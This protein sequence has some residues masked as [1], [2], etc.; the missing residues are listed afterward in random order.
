MKLIFRVTGGPDIG[1][2]H[3]YRSYSLAEAFTRYKGVNNILFIINSELEDNLIGSN[4]N[5]IVSE[6]FNKDIEIIRNFK[7]DLFILDTYLGNSEY[8]LKVREL[9][10]IM[11]FDDN[12]DIYDSNIPHILLNGNVHANTLNYSISKSKLSLLGPN[13]LVMKKEYW[14][15]SDEKILPKEG[16]LITT[17]GTDKH[18]VSYEILN[19]LKGINCKKTVIIGP[20]YHTDLIKKIESIQDNY[21]SIIYKP[22]SLKK[23]IGSSKIG[24]TAGGSTIY[25]IISQNSIPLI[26]SLAEN[27]EKICDTFMKEGINYFGAFPKI[28]F[29]SLYECTRLYLNAEQKVETNSNKLVDGQGAFRVVNTVSD[30]LKLCYDES[31]G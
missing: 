3:F 2:G 10:K 25:E 7:P 8:L 17:G 18:G 23:Y 30:Y 27:Q 19:G 21:T 5:Y 12:N 9:T 26:F 16:L 28:N 15:K 20:G 31:K 13:F 29:D 4:Y 1:Y 24:I 22:T 14:D 11:I 6:S